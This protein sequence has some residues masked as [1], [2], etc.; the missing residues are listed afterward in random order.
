MGEALWK[1]LEAVVEE[2]FTDQAMERRPRRLATGFPRLDASGRRHRP[3]THGSGRQPQPGQVYLCP[4]GGGIH[5]GGRRRS[6]GSDRN[7]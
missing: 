7:R 1:S 2:R 3:G 4:P 5:G 6:R